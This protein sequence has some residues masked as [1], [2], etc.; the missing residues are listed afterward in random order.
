MMEVEKNRL[1]LYCMNILG[2]FSSNRNYVIPFLINYKQKE[3]D[4]GACDLISMSPYEPPYVT[5]MAPLI[6]PHAHSVAVGRAISRISPVIG[7][8]I[9]GVVIYLL[10]R[11]HVFVQGR[12]IST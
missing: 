10:L 1:T 2:L 3:Y 5:V 6:S 11:G 12:K 7:V 8:V 4:K 9:A